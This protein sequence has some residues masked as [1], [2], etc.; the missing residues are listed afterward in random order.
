MEQVHLCVGLLQPFIDAVLAEDW[1]AVNQLARHVAKAEKEADRKKLSIRKHLPKSLFLPVHRNDLLELLTQQDKLA[2]RTR[3]ITSL[4]QGR[5][6]VIPDKLQEGMQ[7]YVESAITASNSA[8]EAIEELDELL[9]AGFRG[10]ELAKVETILRRLD[11]TENNID[12]QKIRL[13]KALF[14]KE[15]QMSAIDVIFLYN[16]IDKIGVLADTAH[17]V[18]SRLRLLI[19]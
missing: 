14:K 12:R 7:N 8:L 11:K 1:D 17:H 2:N 6:M 19:A 13:R 16:I 10:P 15:K 5:K 4:M 9:S 18:G 3:D